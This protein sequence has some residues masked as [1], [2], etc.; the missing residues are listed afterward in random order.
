MNLDKIEKKLIWHDFINSF[1][2]IR[3]WDKIAKSPKTT[4]EFIRTYHKKLPWKYLIARSDLPDSFFWDFRYKFNSINEIRI[5]LRKS[6]NV[7]HKHKLEN[8]F[9]THHLKKKR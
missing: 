4:L 9:Q 3:R 8:W 1:S 2:E 5:A 6:K 7:N